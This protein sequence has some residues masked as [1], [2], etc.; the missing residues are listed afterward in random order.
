VPKAVPTE[1]L[2]WGLKGAEEAPGEEK[3]PCGDEI[4]PLLALT[5]EGL[6]RLLAHFADPDS[7]YIAIPHPEIA[8]TYNDYGHLARI[9]E[10][11][12]A[13]VSP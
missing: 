6:Y 5:R 8:P 12:D 3:A 11:R 4:E 9:G 13:G 2:Y 10:W 1:L 7:A